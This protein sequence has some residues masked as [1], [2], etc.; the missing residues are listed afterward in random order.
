MNV[1]QALYEAVIQ[2]PE[3]QALSDGQVTL[4]YQEFHQ[5]SL[6]V[7]RFLQ[8]SGMQPGD[9]LASWLPN[10]TEAMV[11]AYA[12]WW[13]GAVFVP[14]NTRW[15][16]T[17]LA[18]VLADAKPQFLAILDQD[19]ERIIGAHLDIPIIEVGDGPAQPQNVRTIVERFHAPA[20]PLPLA[21]RRDDQAALLMYTSGTTGRPKGVIQTHRNN[22]AA[23]AMVH[24][25]WQITHRD[26]FLT[27]VPLFHVGGMQ[28]AALPGLTAGAQVTLVPGWSA[29]GWLNIAAATRPT[30]T[31]LVTTMLVDLIRW[32]ETGGGRQ[33]NLDSLR[34]AAMGGSPTPPAIVEK[35][36]QVL[37]VKLTELYGQTELTGLSV[38]Y[39]ADEDWRP[40]S[41][42]RA[43]SQVLDSALYLEGRAISPPPPNAIGELLFRGETISP[44]YWGQSELTDARRIDGWFRTG[45][46]VSI[47]NEGYLFYRDRVD[48]MIVS[49]GENIYPAEV[50]AALSEIP[51]ISQVAVIGTPHPRWGQQV[52]ALVVADNPEL[53]ADDIL[54]H[55]EQRHSLSAYKRPRRIDMVSS[56][57]RTGSGKVNKV[58]LKQQ[59]SATEDKR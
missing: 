32:A 41:M 43:Q 48:D 19:R 18:D 27:A 7:A 53:T 33:P 46:I 34:V 8:K 56:L 55:I 39:R 20:A 11:L 36:R 54:A 25:S 40:G 58:Q 49:G 15:S 59:Y 9:R 28:C 10:V 50:E 2:F 12:T 26:R 5:R 16:V 14:L 52:T 35:F 22:S 47:D 44:G 23:I 6:A 4:T 3:R 30:I 24:E 38:T 13:V 42:G 31:G 21:P 57:P 29:A 17:E 1:A 51:G 37:G 45:D